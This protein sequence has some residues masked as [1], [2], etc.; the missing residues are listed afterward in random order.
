MNTAMMKHL[1]TKILLTITALTPAFVYAQTEQ[2]NSALF[3]S[4]SIV[5]YTDGNGW[6]AALGFKLDYL[7]AYKGSDH[8]VL[9]I[10]P[11]GAVQWR[12]GNHVFFWEGF[13]LNNT[14]LGWRGAIKPNWLI[15]AGIKHE[16]VIPAGR[17]QE[18]AITGLPHRGSHML[19]YLEVKNMM[20][21]DNKNWV[22]GRLSAGSSGYGWLGKVAMGHNFGTGLD[23]MGA[24]ISVFST[25][26]SANHLNN[27]FGVSDVDAGVSDLQ[28]IDL[29]AGYLSSG[30]KFVVRKNITTNMQI[31][32]STSIEVYSNNIAKSDLVRDSSMANADISVVWKF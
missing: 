30:V 21:R 28:S 14:A 12:T 23:N 16:I 6:G 7:P 32:A 17:S 31:I 11:E 4:P 24:E 26:G 27:Y 29:N 22:S 25:V 9:E 15:E 20:T 2:D 18:A 8:Y 13:D 1:A 19:G 5:N 10:K 3:N